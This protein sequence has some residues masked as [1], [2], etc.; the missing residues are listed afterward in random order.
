MQIETIVK[1]LRERDGNGG[2]VETDTIVEVAIMPLSVYEDDVKL[3]DFLRSL[4]GMF[5]PIGKLMPIGGGK[6]ERQKVPF[7]YAALT[8]GLDLKARDGVRQGTVNA[9][10]KA[11]AAMEDWLMD[12]ANTSLGQSYRMAIK[13]LSGRARQNAEKAWWE[14]NEKNV[15]HVMSL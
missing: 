11:R 7:G 15:E 14:M 13:G 1:N 8:Q 12:N 10:T 9:E 4:D 3:V 5:V 2:S 6:M